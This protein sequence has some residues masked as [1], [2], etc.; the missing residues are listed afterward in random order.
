MARALLGARIF[1]GTEF[2]AG[3][4]VLIE[5][6]RITAVLPAA[7]LPQGAELVRLDGGL[8]APGFI[9]LQ[10]NGGGGVQFNDAPSLESIAAIGRAQRR[11][12]TTGFL[13]TLIT[14]RPAK[15]TQAIAAAETG[16]AAGLPGLL[17][18]HLEGPF[19]NPERCGIHDP[20]WIRA[21]SDADLAEL[22]ALHAGRRLVT[23]APERVPPGAIRR[24]TDAGVIVFAG[25]SDATYAEMRAAQAEGLAGCTHL[26]NA[27][28]Q[29]G[30][31]E[32]GVVGA[33]LDDPAGYCGLIVDGHHVHPAS[34]RLALAAKG[35]D[36]LCLVTDAMAIAGTDQ[37]AFVLQGRTIYRRG[38]RLTDAA[39]TLAGAD[40][41]M[42]SAVRNSVTLLEV[43]LEAALRMASASPAACLGL[44]DRLGRLAAGYQADLV[45][46]DDDLQVQDCWLQGRSL[47]EDGLR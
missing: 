36:R 37:P 41:D 40:L 3:H 25:H 12:G 2:L 38:G 46:L 39:G 8:L 9:D 35:P 26:F 18:L 11:F 29:L 30:S 6:G 19:L 20:A 21:P 32:P 47:A 13:P 42:A 34:L 44:A 28:R 24:L 31:R 23:L 14:D 43:P 22:A 45:H 1:T 5:A 4:A 27:M 10:I 7:E 16:L 15:L 33:A 17:G